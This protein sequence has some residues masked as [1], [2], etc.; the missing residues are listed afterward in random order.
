MRRTWLPRAALAVAACALVASC[1]PAREPLWHEAWTQQHVEFW[2]ERGVAPAAALRFEAKHSGRFFRARA[3]N[4][5]AGP[6]D[7]VVAGPGGER[8][9]SVAPGGAEDLEWELPGRGA[10]D[11]RVT[12]GLELGEPRLVRPRSSAPLVV[13]AL[14]DTFRADHVRPDLTPRLIE[15]FRDGERF[16][17]AESNASWTLPSVASLFTSRPTIELTSADGGI[18]AIP[19]GVA[20]WAEA[21]RARG[22]VGGAVVANLT[23]NVPNDFGKGFDAYVVP[24]RYTPDYP[25]TAEMVVGQARAWLRAHRGE[26]A[27]LYVHFMDQH[28]PYH[29][30][31][32]GM[33]PMASIEPL[34][35]RARTASPEETRQRKD[36]YASTVRYLDRQLGAFL[37][38]L[39]PQAVVAFTADHGEA[40]GE[41]D[42]CWG[43]GLTVYREAVHVPLL[44]RGPGV[45][46][47]VEDARAVQLLDLAP[48]LLDLAGCPAPPGMAGRSLLRGG[49]AQPQVAVTFGAGPLRW[50]WRAGS[51]VVT[52]HTRPQPGLAPESEV[53]MPEARPLPVGAFR[54]DLA[55]DPGEE[56]PEPLDDATA[57]AAAGV[58]ARGLGKLVPGLQVFAAGCRGPASVAFDAPGR[59][60]VA[61]VFSV[62]GTR[63]DVSGERVDVRWD[64]A[65]PFALA[66]F[67]GGAPVRPRP[68]AGSAWRWLDASGQ[69]SIGAPGAYLWWDSRSA[70]IQRDYE[71]TLSRLR[72]LGYIH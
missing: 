59:L 11:A 34:A 70:P 45:P 23:I 56:H 66:A 19:V 52:V 8:R 44:L 6:G 15:A 48:T 36:A 72:S 21:L 2:W 61:Q 5:T 25:P 64:D 10:Y 63:I 35:N 17:D 7:V 69:L 50:R 68:A 3:L 30:H 37:A 1:G 47:G 20:S 41:H 18:V 62:G 71:E 26:P 32:G 49:G 53:K 60:R 65:F 38:E 16:T 13:L 51:R 31:E 4:P 43:H 39:P 29:D 67:G 24:P 33:A 57:L 46:R 22:F 12:P 58:F 28:A 9:W 54:F 42:G 55:R 27:F 14:A 40:F